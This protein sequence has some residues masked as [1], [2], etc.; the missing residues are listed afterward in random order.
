MTNPET[1]EA[2]VD[3]NTPSSLFI[4]PREITDKARVHR[5]SVRLH[6]AETQLMATGSES[7]AAAL[8][9]AQKELDDVLGETGL[10]EVRVSYNTVST[11][12]TPAELT[13]QVGVVDTSGTTGFADSSSLVRTA[14]VFGHPLQ[15]AVAKTATLSA[16]DP[17]TVVVT[18]TQDPNTARQDVLRAAGVIPENDPAGN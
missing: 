9:D 1:E 11:N 17:N 3:E 8:K 5:A 13:S 2:V 10:G 7:A 16:P 6:E 15:Q 12:F 18:L 4:D 14:T